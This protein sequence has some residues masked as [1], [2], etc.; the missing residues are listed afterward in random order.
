RDAVKKGASAVIGSRQDIHTEV[1]Y[2]LVPDGRAA[3][4]EVSAAFY[5]HPSQSLTVVGVTGTDGKT[6]TTN[7]IYQCLLLAGIPVG[8]IS[9]VNAVIGDT[10]LDTGFHVTTPEAPDVQRYLAQMVDAGLTHV[11]LEVTS[12]GLEQKR[13]SHCNFDIGVVT[14]I[15]HEHLDYHGS[16]QNYLQA[17]QILFDELSVTETKPH[18]NPRLA[19]LNADDKSFNHL[20]NVLSE[21]D[22]V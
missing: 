18:G 5:N 14:N 11:V 19:V 6:T 2:I 12:H 15:V 22:G 20:Q 4:A 13:V 10:V 21:L 8:M 1:P 16:Y 3:L 17:K 7:F 9:T